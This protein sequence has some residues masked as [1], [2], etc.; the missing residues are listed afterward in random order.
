MLEEE[1]REGLLGTPLEDVVQDFRNRDS[2]AMI[3]SELR[4]LV[5]HVKA[6]EILNHQACAFRI[7]IGGEERALARE[8]A[9]FWNQ[10]SQTEAR[11]EQLELAFSSR[12]MT[13]RPTCPLCNAYISGAI[14]AGLD[15]V[16][17]LSIIASRLR[18][19]RKEFGIYFA[20]C[21]EEFKHQFHVK[22]SD[23]STAIREAMRAVKLID[24]TRTLELK[25]PPESAFLT[26]L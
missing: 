17:G 3:L 22:K 8:L 12:E 23:L 21:E 5:P 13:L 15:D 25:R 16:V 4:T 11:R 20:F 26:F 2:R 19:R 18:G 24:K 1:D 9:T 7:S 14:H 10:R 6:V